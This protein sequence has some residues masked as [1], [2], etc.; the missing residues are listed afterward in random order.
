MDD[1]LTSKADEF[2]LQAHSFWHQRGGRMTVVREII[3]RSIADRK[4]AFIADELWE[5]V[6]KI[7]RGVSIASIYRTLTDLS[8]AGLLR[9]IH[10]PQDERSFVVAGSTAASAGHLICKDCHRIVPLNDECL[11]L[12]EGA[13]IRGLG[14]ETGGMHLQI[15][16]TCE[17]MKRSGACEN[18]SDSNNGLPVSK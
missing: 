9:E 14:F 15:E 17:S 10:G 8:Q 12:R 11:A 1:A 13:M 7:D 6:R 16:A 3:C 5:D 18:H 4:A 2:R